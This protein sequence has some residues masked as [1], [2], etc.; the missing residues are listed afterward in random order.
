MPAVEFS[1]DPATGY[2]VKCHQSVQMHSPESFTNRRGVQMIRAKCATC[3][4]MVHRFVGKSS[5]ATTEPK[6]TQRPKR[7][8]KSK[9]DTTPAPPTVDP[10][11]A[12]DPQT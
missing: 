2:C 6:D 9:A 11:A 7:K 8:R 4:S 5:T 3:S 10:P 1:A 12:L